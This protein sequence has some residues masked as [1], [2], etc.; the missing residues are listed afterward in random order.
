MIWC[1]PA[2]AK[3]NIL[4]YTTCLC[5]TS[6]TAVNLNQ[7]VQQLENYV[8][9]H[10]SNNKQTHIFN[11]RK[12]KHVTHQQVKNSNQLTSVLN[13]QKTSQPTYQSIKQSGNQQFKIR[14]ETENACERACVCVCE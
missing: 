1:H 13:S 2:P 4:L 7:S 11:S 10:Q 6:P 9:H 12:Q 3:R 8:E 5:D 14:R